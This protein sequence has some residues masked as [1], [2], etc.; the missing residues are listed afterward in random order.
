MYNI[1]QEIIEENLYIHHPKEGDPIYAVLIPINKENLPMLSQIGFRIVFLTSL[2]E[3]ITLETLNAKW[4]HH[5]YIA[6]PTVIDTIHKFDGSIVTRCESCEYRFRDGDYAAID[7]TN[8]N[9]YG[10]VTSDTRER[11]WHK[12]QGMT[13]TI[14]EFLERLE[15]R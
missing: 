12:I 6:L 8:K 10:F 9:H 11:M 3:P 7:L 2:E 13:E 1:P 4:L 5:G 15:N 14:E